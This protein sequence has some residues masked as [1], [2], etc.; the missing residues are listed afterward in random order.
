MIDP[1]YLII[2]LMVMKESKSFEAD[3][4]FTSK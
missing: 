3:G 2:I 4:I 1:D